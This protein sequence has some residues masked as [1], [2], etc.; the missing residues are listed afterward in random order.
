MTDEY[1][2]KKRHDELLDAVKGQW[3]IA[4]LVL[5]PLWLIVIL[6]CVIECQLYY[7]WGT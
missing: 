3:E 5:M 1:A 6:L 4:K 2:D 7:H